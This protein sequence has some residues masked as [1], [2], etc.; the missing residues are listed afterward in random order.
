MTRNSFTNVRELPE[1]VSIPEDCRILFF[2]RDRESFFWLSHFYAADIVI[3]GESWPTVEHYFQS[4]KSHDPEFRAVIRNC[5]HPGMAKR[6]AAAPE[7]PRKTSGQSWFRAH[8]QKHR[9]DWRDVRL[10]IMRHADRA[11][12]TQHPALRRLLLMT[13]NAEIF[14]D[15]TMDAFWGTGSDGLGENWA[16]RILMEIRQELRT[17][18]ETIQ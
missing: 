14:E 18:V 12:F 16:G 5:V 11:K 1:S 15:T 10:D 3:D 7:G 4:Q 6:F 9:S 2:E 8:D 17:A 13:G